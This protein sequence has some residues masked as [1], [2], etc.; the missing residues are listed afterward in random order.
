MTNKQVVKLN[1]DLLT[2]EKAKTNVPDKQQKN[3]SDLTHDVL[4]GF[5][6]KANSLGIELKTNIAPDVYAT[7][8][9]EDWVCICNNLIDN[10]L[11]YSKAGGRVTVELQKNRKHLILTVS[12]NGIG[13]PKNEVKKIG[14]RFYRASNS[15]RVS[16]TGLGIA[17]VMQIT[18]SYK[19][20]LSINSNQNKGTIVTVE[21]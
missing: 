8:R 19:G 12:D 14:D 10:A 9:E 6:F 18:S 7:I 5:T 11:K 21:L 20:T 2:L 17:I 3:I 1:E 16:G 13:I 15:G 4:D